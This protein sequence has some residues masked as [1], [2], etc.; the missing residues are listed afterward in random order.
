MTSPIGESMR[1]PSKHVRICYLIVLLCLAVDLSLFLWTAHRNGTYLEDYRL[2]SYSDARGYVVLGR[3]I[4]LRGKYSRA[5]APPYETDVFRTP[6]YPLWAGGL[7]ILGGIKALYLSQI[8]LHAVLCVLLFFLSSRLFG[9]KA[10]LVSGLFCASDLMLSTLS[11]TAMSEVLFVVLESAL[12]FAFFSWTRAGPAASGRRFLAI[13]LVSGALMLVRPGGLYLPVVLAAL[14]AVN[15]CR[16]G[17]WKDGLRRAS[18][19]ILGAVIVAGPW[20]ARNYLVFRIPRLTTNDTVVLVYYTAAGS[21]QV[22][23]GVDQETAQRMIA[24]EYGLEPPTKMW[25]YWRYGASPTEMD[26]KAR[27]ALPSLLT[28]YPLDLMTSSALGVARGLVSPS[29]RLMGEIVGERWAPGELNGLSTFARR[30]VRR[31]LDHHPVL[32]GAYAWQM[33][34]T[35]SLLLFAAVGIIGCMTSRSARTTGIALAAISA[36]FILLLGVQGINAYFRF[37]APL[38]PLEYLAAGSMVGLLRANPEDRTRRA[39]RDRRRG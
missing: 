32:F 27:E 22:H 4:W 33:L 6:V 31:L 8:F 2:N 5:T 35:L 29:V 13:G 28:K 24:T 1:D 23:F 21:Y 3:N 26:R 19:L 38:L 39:A 30:A 7:E 20:I 10:G 17:V 16:L 37:R 14:I 36:Y 25:N 11:L 12:L 18:A 15:A 34:H 9:V